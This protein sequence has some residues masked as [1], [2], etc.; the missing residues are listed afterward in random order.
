MAMIKWIRLKNI[1]ED[2]SG[3]TVHLHLSTDMPTDHIAGCEFT[4]EDA[5][6]I[7]NAAQ[8]KSLDMIIRAISHE[9]QHVLN[10]NKDHRIDFDEKW[11]LLEKRITEEYSGK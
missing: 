5:H 3:F 10:G 4:K 6:I 1:C 7:L 2:I 11:M 9:L 8:V